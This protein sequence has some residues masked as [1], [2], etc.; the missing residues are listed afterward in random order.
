MFLDRDGVLIEDTGYP[1]DPEAL[2]LLPGGGEGLRRLAT[3]GWGLVVV[4]NQSGAARGYFTLE[5]LAAV[6]DRLEQLVEAEGVQFNGIFFCPHHPAGSVE[7]LAR[8]CACRK[9]EP[10]MLRAAARML[11]LELPRCWIVGDRDSD[12][13]A[14]LAAGVPGLLVGGEPGGASGV[15]DRV[16]GLLDAADLICRDVR[17]PQAQSAGDR[18]GSGPGVRAQPSSR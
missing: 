7:A 1:D 5:R 14:G 10:G 15:R 16:G 13:Q 4:T 8:H 12:I 3:A 11:G 9:P 17:A 6:H 2:V 18:D